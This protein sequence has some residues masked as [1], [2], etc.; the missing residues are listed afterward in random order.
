MHVAMHTCVLFAPGVRVC[1]DAV[2]YSK[3]RV[4]VDELVWQIAW[5]PML[6]VH[7]SSTVYMCSA[8]YVCRAAQPLTSRC[9]L[10]AMMP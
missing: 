6:A 7:A 3:E 2:L 4:L 10:Q 8:V 1:Y 9:M 5:L